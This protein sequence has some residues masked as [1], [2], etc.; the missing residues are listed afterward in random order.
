M[1]FSF[2]N[3]KKGDNSTQECDDGNGEGTNEKM[4]EVADLSNGRGII[5]VSA[6]TQL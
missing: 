6:L 5:K 4:L 3:F 1:L 2:Y